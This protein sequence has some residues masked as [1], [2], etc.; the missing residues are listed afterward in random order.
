MEEKQSDYIVRDGTEWP[1]I[2]RIDEIDKTR[3]LAISVSRR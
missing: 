1:H 2:G 3:G